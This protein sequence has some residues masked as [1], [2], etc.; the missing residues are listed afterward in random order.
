MFIQG[1]SLQANGNIGNGRRR[2][3]CHCECGWMFGTESEKAN[4]IHSETAIN[5]FVGKKD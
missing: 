1:T 2:D 5:V 3:T 4:F